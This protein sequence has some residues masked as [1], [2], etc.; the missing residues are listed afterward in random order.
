M[1]SETKNESGT[2]MD[3][4][5]SFSRVTDVVTRWTLDFM[6]VRLCR[7]FKEGKLD[8]FNET[9]STLEAM[10]QGSS[11]KGEVHD[12]KMMISAFLARVMHGK[13]LDV[14]F[15]EDARV[16]P[17]MSA[18]KIWPNLE[19]TVADKSLFKNVTILLLVQSVAVCMEKGQISSA[20]SA[21]KWFENNHGFP[22]NL[23]VKLSTI[24]T[25]REIYHPF[26]T[27]FSFSR[28]LETVQSYLDAFLE[29][30]PC[31]YLLKAA[32]KMLQTSQNMEG[33]EDA[34]TEDS[35]PSETANVS[36]EDRKRE[37]N[38]V[39]LRTKRK[40]L[41]TKMTDLW[42]PDSCK[43]PFV[44]V[45]R[46]PMSELSQMTSQKSVD[47]K[48]N[49]KKTRKAP[50]KWTSQLDKYLKKG[51]KQH[52]QGKW[53]RILMDYDFEGRTGTMLKDRWRVLMRANEVS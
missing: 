17:L 12:E 5:V 43:K 10:C 23:R 39:C 48:K 1:E 32:T 53:S 16:M 19:D 38:T 52:G 49:N 50:Q 31:D 41:P 8:E 40:L 26:L 18:A 46:I 6:F 33:L 3:G 7:H 25:Q 15:E 36:T 45:R 42:K 27:S 51:V 37:E 30:N 21:L 14:Q 35:C 47:T 2:A 34:E 22:Q 29:K 11:L 20:S 9:L 4:S 44:S 24:V 13:Q 28:L